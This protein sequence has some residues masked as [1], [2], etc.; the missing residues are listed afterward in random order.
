[1]YCITDPP[2]YRLCQNQKSKSMEYKRKHCARLG[3]G[4]STWHP[5]PTVRFSASKSSHL[6][7][8]RTRSGRPVLHAP[9]CL[10]AR[11]HPRHT[12]FLSLRERQGQSSRFVCRVYRNCN[13]QLPKL[14]PIQESCCAKKCLWMSMREDTVS[15]ILCFIFIRHPL[16]KACLQHSQ[17]VIKLCM[18]FMK[19]PSQYSVGQTCQTAQSLTCSIIEK[20]TYRVRWLSENASGM[21]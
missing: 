4:A 9:H 19:E 21:V 11:P 14:L 8:S 16:S 12:A 7:F 20:T 5:F 15:S 2:S 3:L 6:H 13:Y 1:M 10:L 17:T 18:W